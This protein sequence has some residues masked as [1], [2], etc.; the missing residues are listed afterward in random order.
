MTIGYSK[1]RNF[2]WKKFLGLWGFFAVFSE[3]VVSAK[4]FEMRDP[5]NFTLA[6]IL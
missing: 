2:R 3:K 6:K 4:V 1:G 5:L